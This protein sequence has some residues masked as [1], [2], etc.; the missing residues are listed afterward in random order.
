MQYD[1]LIGHRVKIEE[2]KEI[3][4]EV[5]GI[6]EE[7]ESITLTE[8]KN[9][10]SYEAFVVRVIELD[11]YEKIIYVRDNG[12]V[13]WVRKKKTCAYDALEKIFY[14]FTILNWDPDEYSKKDN[15][16][17]KNRFELMDI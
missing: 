10:E 1:F 13:G 2:V 16:K 14:K 8:N 6:K 7:D 3:K 5:K 17:K 9:F 15:N 11:R 4:E 12:R